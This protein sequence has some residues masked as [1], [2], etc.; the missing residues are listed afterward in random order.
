MKYTSAAA[1][2]RIRK[3][4]EEKELY[5][6]RELTSS[7]YVAAVD[8]TPLVPEF[9][10]EQNTAEIEKIDAEIVRLKHAVNLYNALA[11]INVDGEIMSVDQILIRMAQINNRIGRLDEMRKALPRQRVD[12]TLVRG[13]KPEYRY[14]NYDIEK[15]RADYEQFLRCFY[16][17]KADT[18]YMPLVIANYEGGG[19][20]D[21]NKKIS[22]QERKE[23]IKM[24]LP[25]SKVRKYDFIRFITLAHVRTFIAS[26]KITAGMYNSLKGALYSAKDKNKEK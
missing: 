20:S 16:R 18:C 6:S 3:L 24:Y 2:K 23:I 10:Y 15:V 19:F 4:T 26:N 8:E 14:A 5:V 21:Q 11:Q 17:E 22:E 12:T 25:A 13:A 9:D 1:N 7:S